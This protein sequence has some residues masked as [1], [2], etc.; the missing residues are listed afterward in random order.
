MS[1]ASHLGKMSPP[2]AAL[3]AGLSACSL[4]VDAGDLST[5][6]ATPSQTDASTEDGGTS[7]GSVDAT[8]GR[9]TCDADLTRDPLHCGACF[10]DCL[11]GACV[12]SQCQ[13]F[14]VAA[15]VGA[16]GITA[17]ES[18]VYFSALVAGE[19]K[20]LPIEGGPVS[21]LATGLT[22]PLH[23]S[24]DATSLYWATFYNKTIQR[25]PKT[26]G[27]VTTM[28]SCK[29]ECLGTAVAGGQLFFSDR[30]TS[31]VYRIPINAV[32]GSTT[33]TLLFG[34]LGCPED[35]D[36][37]KGVLFVASECQ[38]SIVQ[39]PVDTAAATSFATIQDVVSVSIDA[40]YVWAISQARGEVY[41]I[42]VNG[43]LPTRVAMGQ[44]K[45]T[46][47]VTTAKAVFFTHDGNVMRLAK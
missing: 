20:S 19:I 9:A 1:V 30:G 5:G 27:V 7:A 6:G 17:D 14:V 4:L 35:L 12:D 26:G 2:F 21:T 41:R 40:D 28:T 25:M 29:G 3:L 36:V 24:V 44:D 33:P 38:N 10:H 32:A 46:G 11:S 37:A 43:G 8:D 22:S 18:T 15:K 31:S 16:E 13:P 23:L 34:G 39:S 47:I 42:P 45:P